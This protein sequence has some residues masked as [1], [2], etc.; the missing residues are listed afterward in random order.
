MS[1]KLLTTALA[2]TFCLNSIGASAVTS[3]V[4]VSKT[5]CG[6]ASFFCYYD[7]AGRKVSGKPSGEDCPLNRTGLQQKGWKECNEGYPL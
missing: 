4:Q 2:L 7:D 3:R 5:K 1:W 6:D